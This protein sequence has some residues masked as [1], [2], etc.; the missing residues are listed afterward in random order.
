M[1][2]DIDFYDLT[3]YFRA[4][5]LAQVGFIGFIGPLDICKNMVRHQ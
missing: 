5:G 3:Y 2:N 4:P 1:S